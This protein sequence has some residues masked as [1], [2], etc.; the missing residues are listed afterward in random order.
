M[1]TVQ[2]S[3]NLIMPLYWIFLCML[4]MLFQYFESFTLINEFFLRVVWFSLAS[5]VNISFDLCLVHLK[6]ITVMLLF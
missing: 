5:N 2:S 1:S 3:L 4:Q 6:G